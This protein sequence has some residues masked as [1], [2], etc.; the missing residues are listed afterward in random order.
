MYCYPQ[1]YREWMCEKTGDKCIAWFC[2]YCGIKDV[3]RNGSFPN[4]YLECKEQ[5]PA[6]W[7]Q[8]IAKTLAW[9]GITEER[10]SYVMG[11]KCNCKKREV[12]ID[13]VGFRV[14]QFLTRIGV[15]S[16]PVKYI[17]SDYSGIVSL[18]DPKDYGQEIQYRHT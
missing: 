11:G 4:I 9:C 18:T 16:R 7:G 3:D 13:Y 14:N 2:P 15:S 5:Q 12:R 8:A 1:K 10:V 6:R 17:P